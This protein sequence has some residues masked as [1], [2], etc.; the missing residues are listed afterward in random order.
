IAFTLIFLALAISAYAIFQFLKDSDY[1]WGFIKPYRHRGSGTYIC[2]NHL[3]GFLELLLPLA[4]AYAMTGRLKPVT[5]VLVGYAALVILAGIAVTLSRGAWVSTTLALALFFGALMFRRQHRFPALALAAVVVFAGV[6]AVARSDYID[7]RLKQLVSPQGRPGEDMRVALW[8]PA[9]QMWRDHLFWGVG[10][11]HYDTRFRG[12]RPEAVQLTPDRAHNDYLNTLADWGLVGTVLVVSA[13]VLLGVGVAQTWRSRRLAPSDIGGKTTSNKYAFLLGATL[14]LV[15]LLAHS[16]VDFNMHVPANAI[17]VVTLMAL[18]SAHLRFA[19]ERFWFRARLWT[20][21][22]VSLAAVGAAVYLGPRAFRQ[23]A[24][25]VWLDRAEKAPSFSTKQ[26]ALLKRAFALDPGNPFTAYKIGEA[27]RRQ[28]QEGGEHYEG[29]EGMDYRKLASEAMRWFRIGMQLNPWDSRNYAQYGWCLD[30]LD[31]PGE[32]A[33]YF[34]RAEELD[35]NN[36]YN[37]DNIG[38]H[39]VSLGEYAAA[40]P[41]FERSARLEWVGNDI[42][43]AYL[44]IIR[45]RLLESATNSANPAPS[46]GPK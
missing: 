17:L 16:F 2:P 24:E 34:Q 14:G 26:I 36:Y 18:L 1:V 9:W 45:G 23:A 27:L 13:W 6:F 22:A 33:A 5:R 31:R 29:Q 8:G 38:L 21:L 11:A 42:A 28:S 30:W 35:P 19:T 4:M 15:A 7:E 37:L 40:R 43:T 3:G 12:Y 20:N 39:Y 10:P 32:A 44:K 46:P 41:W 25:F